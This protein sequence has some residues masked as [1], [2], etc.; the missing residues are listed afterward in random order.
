MTSSAGNFAPALIHACSWSTC[1]AVKGAPSGGIRFS[2]SCES[3]RAINSLAV[4]LPGTITS[5]SLLPAWMN[6]PASSRSLDF[7]FL[8]PW[9]EEHLLRRS[10]L[11]SFT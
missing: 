3:T 4:A 6:F 2:S 10:G 1:S 9:Q 7:C 8:A 5:P 11:M